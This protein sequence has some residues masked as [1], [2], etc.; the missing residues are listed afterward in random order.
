[1]NHL[2]TRYLLLFR[3]LSDQKQL[4]LSRIN[5]DKYT[6]FKYT[7]TQRFSSVFVEFLMTRNINRQ[8]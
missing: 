3:C 8:L 4:K 5:K 1:M 6:K 2:G 7:N